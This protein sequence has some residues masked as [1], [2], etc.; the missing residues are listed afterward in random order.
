MLKKFFLFFKLRQKK[1]YRYTVQKRVELLSKVEEYFALKQGRKTCNLIF[2]EKLSQNIY[3]RFD[4]E[5][6]CIYINLDLVLDPTRLFDV[7]GTILHEGRHAFQYCVVNQAYQDGGKAHRFS[8]AYKWK[9]AFE[10]YLST[11][12]YNYVDYQNQSIELDANMYAYKQLKKLKYR[13]KKSKLYYKK[14]EEYETWF[15]NAEKNG[16]EKYGIFYKHKIR[17]K[18]AKQA[19]INKKQQ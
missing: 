11:Q 18:N 2:T 12:N 13:Y 8:R 10:G 14:L 7:L 19:K 15:E 17:K 4:S 3:G 5:P 6:W 1:Y 16:K 9:K